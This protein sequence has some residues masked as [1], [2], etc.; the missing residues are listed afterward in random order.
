MHRVFCFHFTAARRRSSMASVPVFC[1]DFWAERKKP[2]RGGT[3]WNACRVFRVAAPS[4]RIVPWAAR[5]SC[6]P[7]PQQLLPVSAAGGG[8]RCCSGRVIL[9][10]GVQKRLRAFLY[11]FSR[12]G[13]ADTPSV[14]ACAVPAPPRGRLSALS[15]TFP[16]CLTL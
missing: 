10:F 9:N 16:L 12:V 3:I 2:G 11:P 15:Q 14:T 4:I 7:L 6:W 1:R 13:W 8:R 5:A